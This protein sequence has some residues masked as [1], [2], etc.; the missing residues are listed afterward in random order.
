L[1]PGNN[2]TLRVLEL[3]AGTGALGIAVERY[4]QLAGYKS[5]VICTDLQPVLPLIRKNIKANGSEARAATLSWGS[6]TEFDRTLELLRNGLDSTEKHGFDVVLAC[7][8]LYWGGWSLLSSDTR[9]LLRRTL[10]SAAPS[11]SGCRVLIGFTVRDV[12]REIGILKSLLEPWEGHPGYRVDCWLDA[13]DGVVN[14]MTTEDEVT[15][16]ERKMEG[17]VVVLCL[18]PRG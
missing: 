1:F 18:V 10:D 7:E 15:R 8:C 16:I 2:K 12:G 14:Q 3:G 11:G 13:E 17:D 4:L 5:S 9:P 6:R